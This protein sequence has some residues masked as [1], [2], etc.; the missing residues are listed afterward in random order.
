VLFFITSL[1]VY[2][3]LGMDYMKQRKEQETLASQITELT[4]ILAEIPEPAQDLE[5]QLAVAQANLAAE[6]SVFPEKMNSSQIISTILRLAT[7]SEVKAIPLVTDPWSTET[8]G[9]Y[10]YHVF[11]SDIAVRGSFSQ[12]LSFISQLEN[13]ELKTLIVEELSIIVSTEQPEDE[14]TTDGAIPITASLDVAIYAQPPA[15]Y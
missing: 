3:Y 8:I 9:E 7:Y 4:Q 13:G 6:Q 15:S 1:V 5:Q 10:E 2:A 11:R 14:V 12:L